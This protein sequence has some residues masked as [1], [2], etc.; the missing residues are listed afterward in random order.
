MEREKCHQ[1]RLNSA[2][3]R[4]EEH[5]SNSLDQLTPSMDHRHPVSFIGGLK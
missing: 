5:D 1:E 4:D 3:R 2:V